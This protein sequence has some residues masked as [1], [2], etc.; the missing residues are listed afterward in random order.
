VYAGATG[1]VVRPSQRWEIADQ[2]AD[3]KPQGFPPCERRIPRHFRADEP[4][5]GFFALLNRFF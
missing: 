1:S 3:D 4:N 5:T 2:K